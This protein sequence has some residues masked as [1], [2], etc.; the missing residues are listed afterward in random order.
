MVDTLG[1]SGANTVASP[2]TRDETDVTQRELQDRG[3]S[4]IPVDLEPEESPL[5]SG[6]QL[7]SYQSWAARLNFCS[8]DRADVQYA[9]KELMRMLGAPSEQD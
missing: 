8:L 4:A 5:L 6:E 1:L 9:V 3:L 2:G 7:K